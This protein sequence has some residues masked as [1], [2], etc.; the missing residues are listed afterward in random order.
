MS[1]T[2]KRNVRRKVRRNTKK[3]PIT[4]KKYSKKM[5][6]RTLVRRAQLPL[7]VPMQM[8]TTVRYK[9]QHE[10]TQAAPGFPT[11][12]Y[13]RGNGAWDPYYPTGGGS[14]YMWAV[15]SLMYQNYR[16]Y[17]CKIRVRFLDGDVATTDSIQVFVRPTTANNFASASDIW[18]TSTNQPYCKTGYVQDFTNMGRSI[19]HYMTTAKIFGIPK[20]G[21]SLEDKYQSI[22]STGPANEWDWEIGMQCSDQGS[23]QKINLEVSLKYYLTFF[24]P[25]RIEQT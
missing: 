8:V 22:V 21:V 3:R 4:R 19:S 18:P 7:Y 14:P 15:Y 10:V 5:T 16:V 24:N 17:G 20:I 9:H 6:S 25:T 1:Y 13:F 12:T 23:T 11:Y 2:R